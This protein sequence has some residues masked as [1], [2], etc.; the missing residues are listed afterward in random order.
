MTFSRRD[1]VAASAAGLATFTLP[2]GAI[3]DPA[4]VKPPLL[5]DANA[6]KRLVAWGSYTCP[7][8]ALLS[9]R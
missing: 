1:F 2:F 6:P 9:Q 5:G 4:G 7:Y 3:A 8:T